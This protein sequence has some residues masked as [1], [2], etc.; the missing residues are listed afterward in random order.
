[1]LK[2]GGGISPLLHVYVNSGVKL[3]LTQTAPIL[4]VGLSLACDLVVKIVCIYGRLV[5]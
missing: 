4:A 2:V 5:V 3:F 1:M